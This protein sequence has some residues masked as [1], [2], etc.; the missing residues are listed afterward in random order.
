MPDIY[1]YN[2]ALLKSLFVFVLLLSTNLVFSQPVINSFSPASGA[3]G[4]T[5]T[6]T[7]SNFNTT[8]SNNTVYFGYVKAYVLSATATTLTVTV[9]AGATYQPISVTN[10][11]LTASS[12]VPFNVTFPG[13]GASFAANSFATGVSFSSG[14]YYD[15]CV[16]DV[17]GDGKNDVI[18][19]NAD[20]SFS[21]FRNTSANNSV[22]FAA[23]VDYYPMSSPYAIT[24]AD[25]D[26][27][28]ALW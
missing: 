25:F 19:A 6:I 7:G 27:P 11:N 13:I 4:T 23:K 18:T 9:P 1:S 16:G 20:N 10:N 26:G 8:P 17:D 24:L 28:V 15:V 2:R 3:I 5:V 21:V 22:N 14:Q 12:Q